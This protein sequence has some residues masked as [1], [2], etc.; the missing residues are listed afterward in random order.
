MIKD[1]FKSSDVIN[2]PIILCDCPELENTTFR[3][4]LGA[5]KSNNKKAIKLPEW[6][7]CW[8]WDNN[9][10]MICCHDGSKLD[11]RRTNDVYYTLT[12]I[13]RED[14]MVYRIEEVDK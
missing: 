14:W 1:E 11:I 13:C 8:I 7:G 4:A 10:I 6:D 9:T 12:N 3:V 2:K 5:I